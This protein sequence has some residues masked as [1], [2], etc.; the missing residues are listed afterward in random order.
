LDKFKDG[1][2]DIDDPSNIGTNGDPYA[3]ID[4]TG[5]DVGASLNFYSF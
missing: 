5:F 1:T 2:V 4:F 3:T